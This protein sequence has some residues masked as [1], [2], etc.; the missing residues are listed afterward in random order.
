M[1]WGLGWKRPSEIFRITLN[2]GTE[3]FGEDLNRTS[4]SSSSCS[5]TSTPTSSSPPAE[6]STAVEVEEE[7]QVGFK[8]E[9]DWSAGDDEDQVALRLQSQLMVALPAPQDCVTVDLKAAEEGKENVE[10]EMKV[11]KRRE[12]LRGV[13]V[14]K[15]GTGQQS[16]GV[17]VLSRLFRSDGGQHWKSVTLLSLFGCGLSVRIFLSF[18]VFILIEDYSN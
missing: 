8:I 9:L 7:P 6:I 11:E 12:E 4:T 14:G 2:Y 3:D 16:D 1:S 10:V 15:T 13:I 5:S 17:G 18:S